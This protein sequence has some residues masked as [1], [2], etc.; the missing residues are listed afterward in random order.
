MWVSLAC[1]VYSS[2]LH[3]LRIPPKCLQ[4]F[5]VGYL[6]NSQPCVQVHH[7]HKKW[8]ESSRQRVDASFSVSTLFWYISSS[9][10]VSWARP[11]SCRS[12]SDLWDYIVIHLLSA[13]SVSSPPADPSDHLT[14]LSLHLALKAV[15]VSAVHCLPDHW[16]P[17]SVAWD[18]ESW[19]RVVQLS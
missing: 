6:Y 1:R 15:T 12:G 16:M 8:R 14:T 9:S 4:M 11:N 13:V 19:C 5:V 3:T 17:F 2:T 10:R 18:S 7:C